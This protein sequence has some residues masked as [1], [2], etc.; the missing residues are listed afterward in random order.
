MLKR[1]KQILRNLNDA[2]KL[3]V[4]LTDGDLDDTDS[5][6]DDVSK[7]TIGSA[8]PGM[9]KKTLSFF[10]VCISNA[11]PGLGEFASTL[12]PDLQTFSVEEP[13]APV[14]AEVVSSP[15]QNLFDDTEDTLVVSNTEQIN[16]CRHG[17]S[18]PAPC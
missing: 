9:L 2:P 18:R 5:D 8:E 16:R 14:G 11:L 13:L 1:L 10:K 17:R 12:H 3:F 15:Q 7:D 4:R 6:Q